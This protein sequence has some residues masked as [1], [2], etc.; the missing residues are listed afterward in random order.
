MSKDAEQAGESLVID[1]EAMNIVNRIAPGSRTLGEF[2]FTGGLLV[3]GRIEGTLHVTG[4]PIVLMPGGEIAGTIDGDGD[5]ILAGTVLQRGDVDLSEIAV[6]GT[7]FMAQTLIA[8][9]NITALAFKT[10]HGA[11]VLGLIRTL[12]SVI[13]P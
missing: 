12:G 7:V 2:H 11:Q 4:G 6:Q 9:A 3:E 5:A 13:A 10:Y 8:K 1:P